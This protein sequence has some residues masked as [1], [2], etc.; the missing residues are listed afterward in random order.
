MRERLRGQGPRATVGREA[1]RPYRSAR[2]CPS[3]GTAAVAGHI[4]VL[5]DLSLSFPLMSI[6]MKVFQTF[7]P[8]DCVLIWLILFILL[9]TVERARGTGPRTMA[10][11]NTRH[12]VQ[13]T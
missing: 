3:Q 11:T 13:R 10:A 6:D 8:C 1:L 12:Q 9:Q 7:A 2:A 4:K 5:S